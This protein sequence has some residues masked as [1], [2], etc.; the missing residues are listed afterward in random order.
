MKP[1]IAAVV[2]TWACAATLLVAQTSTPAA[3]RAGP[4]GPAAV[5]ANQA[6]ATQREWLNKYCVS[7]HNARTPLPANDPLRLDSANL[8]DVTAD[9][10]TWERVLRKLSVRAMPPAGTPHPTEAEYAGF[11]GWLA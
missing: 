1:A 9:A 2:L 8:E 4:S 11:T 7:C 10:A 6:A 3:R 5:S